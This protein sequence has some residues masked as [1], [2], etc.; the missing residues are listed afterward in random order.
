MK[1]P[2]MIIH[3]KEESFLL[4][5]FRA[6]DLLKHITFHFRQAYSEDKSDDVS[7]EKYLEGIRRKGIEIQTSDEG[8]QRRLQLN[9]IN[10]IRDYLN[11]DEEESFFPN[12]VILSTDLS[13]FKDDNGQFLDDKITEQL[14]NSE[15]QDFGVIDLPD[16]IMFTIV[17]GQHRLAGLFLAKKDVQDNFDIPAIL[18]LNITINTC[19][20]IFSDVNGTQSTVNRSVIYDLYEMR[21]DSK[22]ISYTKKLHSI[23]KNFNTDRESPLYR[24]IKMLGVGEGAISQSFFVNAVDKAIK[25]AQIDNNSLQDLYND[26]FFYFRAYQRVFFYQWPVLEDFS[27]YEDFRNHSCKVMKE[28]KSQMLKTNGFGGMMKAFPTIY[29]SLEKTERTYQ[30]YHSVIERL[31]GKIDWCNDFNQGTGAKNQDKVK[32]RILEI[33]GLKEE[34]KNKK[35]ASKP[36]A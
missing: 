8:I 19:A 16:D 12:A 7:I 31:K 9:K 17:D 2:Y 29:K 30:D 14:N 22:S 25:A 5:K 24:H 34:N 6:S 35:D 21:T 4:T 28:D 13:I 1:I 18:L 11:N 36:D 27:N 15:N 10:Q 23:C 32:D 33:L 26:L 3:Q 20:K